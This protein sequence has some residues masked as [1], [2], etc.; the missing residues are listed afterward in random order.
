MNEKPER[1]ADFIAHS[2]MSPLDTMGRQR[3]CHLHTLAFA[4]IWYLAP[5]ED[6]FGFMILGKHG[7]IAIWVE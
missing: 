1:A 4:I 6:I 2:G 7:Y 3:P 5:R